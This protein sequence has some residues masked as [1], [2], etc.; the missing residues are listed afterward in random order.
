MYEHSRDHHW[1]IIADHIGGNRTWSCK[2]S[3]LEWY[4]AYPEFNL[5]LTFLWRN[6]DLLMP[7]PSKWTENSCVVRIIS[8]SLTQILIIRKL[9]LPRSFA[10]CRF[11]DHF[12]LSCTLFALLLLQNDKTTLWQ[13]NNGTFP[14]MLNRPYFPERC[15]SHP[16]IFRFEI[17]GIWVALI[18]GVRKCFQ[19]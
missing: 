4:Q 6:F 11:T 2:I 1:Y 18:L 13:W 16:D 19:N 9:T 12:L 5:L 8:F 15:D 17:R 10:F 14:C 7:C 3:R